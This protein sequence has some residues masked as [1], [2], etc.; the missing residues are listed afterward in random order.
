MREIL[1]RGKST[2]G[3]EWVFGNL[4]HVG[5]YCAILELDCE[6]YGNTYLSKDLG[7][8]DGQAVPVDPET[9]GQFIGIRDKKGK[10]I[11]EGDIVSTEYDRICIVEWFVGNDEIGWDLTP[12]NTYENIR[13]H[14]PP[15]RLFDGQYTEIVGNIHDK[16]RS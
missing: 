13:Y 12:I 5:E 8:I 15:R 4:I 16:E 14:K 1:F 6:A 10:K 7:D 9:V 11:F 3:G 2:R